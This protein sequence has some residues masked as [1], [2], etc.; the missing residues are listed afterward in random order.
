[1]EVDGATNPIPAP[2]PTPPVHRITR[3]A[4]APAFSAAESQAVSGVVLN[5][6]PRSRR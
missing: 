4:I 2:T 1:M 5:R 6:P 3:T